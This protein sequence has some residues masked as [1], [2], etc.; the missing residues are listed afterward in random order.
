MAVHKYYRWVLLISAKLYDL[1]SIWYRGYNHFTTKLVALK[2]GE[3]FTENLMPL[4]APAVID[5]DFEQYFETSDKGACKDLN[6]H[7]VKC[8]S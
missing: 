5:I 3:D 1:P 8:F 2:D 4:S 6:Q 7:R